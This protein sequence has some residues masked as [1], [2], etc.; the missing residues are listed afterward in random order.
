MKTW[1][2][3]KFE[4]SWNL[5]IVWI[6]LNENGVSLNAN[7]NINIF[8]TFEYIFSET[9]S[10]QWMDNGQNTFLTFIPAF[11]IVHE[12]YWLLAWFFDSFPTEHS[13][14]YFSS[15]ARNYT[16][17]SGMFFSIYCRLSSTIGNIVERNVKDKT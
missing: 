8:W 6:W 3:N 12:P 16:N 13:K 4:M 15:F 10:T 17:N 11:I 14:V 5:G 9:V 1:L 2:S 7:T